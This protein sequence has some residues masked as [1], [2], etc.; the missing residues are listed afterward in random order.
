MATVYPLI[1]PLRRHRLLVTC[2]HGGN[3]IPAAFATLFASPAARRALASHRGWD[4]GALP[5][6]RY[7]A[8]A[9]SAPSHHSTVS[10]LLIEL[11]RSIG[12]RSLFSLITRTLAPSQR[13]ALLDAYYHP[14]RDAVQQTAG[15]II[16][17]QA[18]AVHISVHTFT[19][20]IHGQWRKVDVGL[21][22]DPTRDYEAA[23]CRLWQTRLATA[24]PGLRVRRNNPYRGSADGLTTALRR[25]WDG[26]HYLGIE[27]E[28]NQ[29]FHT[30]TAAFKQQLYRAIADSYPWR[31]FDDIVTAPRARDL[32]SLKQ[33]D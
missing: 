28:I 21:L 10:R 5:A 14:Y 23:L 25:R 22:F 30:R 8:R 9:W 26:D 29:R 32:H 16:A 12:H 20:R 24:M 11:N 17:S 6:A 13:A 31:Q 15:R 18:T 4:P 33:N 2:E 3:R 7:L 1:C 27:I 19:P